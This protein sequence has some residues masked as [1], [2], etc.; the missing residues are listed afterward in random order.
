VVVAALNGGPRSPRSNQTQDGKRPNAQ[1]SALGDI[2]N[3]SQPGASQQ[4]RTA[5]LNSFAARRGRASAAREGVSS[6][7]RLQHSVSHARCLQ[8]RPR[9]RAARCAH[10]SVSPQVD[11]Y[12]GDSENAQARGAC[13]SLAPASIDST[14]TALPPRAAPR[15]LSPPSAAH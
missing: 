10:A 12:R 15:A 2:S 9:R 11:K 7:G 6:N 5:G 13:L 4:V 1:R 8:T 14:C 3:G